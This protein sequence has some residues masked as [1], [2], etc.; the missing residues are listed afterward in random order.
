MC[1]Q[2]LE[3]GLRIRPKI[4]AVLTKTVH[5]RAQRLVAD[6]VQVKR[7]LP[8]VPEGH[9]V[10]MVGFMI[11]DVVDGSRRAPQSGLGADSSSWTGGNWYF[12]QPV[13]SVVLTILPTVGE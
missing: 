7:A 6:R 4:R 13:A 5:S 8:V 3:V 11:Q 9:G 10:F 1:K 12:G 2:R